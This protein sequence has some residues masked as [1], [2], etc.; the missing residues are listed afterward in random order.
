MLYD[1]ISMKCPEWQ[2]ADNGCQ[3]IEEGGVGVFVTVVSSGDDENV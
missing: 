1:F 3:E 2:K